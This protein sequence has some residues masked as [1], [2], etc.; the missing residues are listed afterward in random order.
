MGDLHEQLRTLLRDISSID[1]DSED[2]IVARADAA[3]SNIRVSEIDEET[4]IDALFDAF[5]GGGSYQPPSS[6]VVDDPASFD[7]ILD[8]LCSSENGFTKEAISVKEQQMGGEGSR[9][10]EKGKNYTTKK[11][12]RRKAGQDEEEILDAA[13]DDNDEW[14]DATKVPGQPKTRADMLSRA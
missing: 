2:E 13:H 3:L 1:V 5:D 7:Q 6:I 9:Y 12:P 4:M 8:S 14:R 11:K 10:D